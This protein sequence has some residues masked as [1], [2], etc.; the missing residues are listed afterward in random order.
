[1]KIGLGKHRVGLGCTV[2]WDRSDIHPSIGPTFLPLLLERDGW[3][4]HLLPAK[5]M[6]IRSLSAATSGSE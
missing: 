6:L 1:V 5:R 2:S 3:F 4:F